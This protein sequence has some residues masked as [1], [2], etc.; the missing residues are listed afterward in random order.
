MCFIKK[1][2]RYA[3]RTVPFVG[4]PEPMNAQRPF[5]VGQGFVK[6]PLSWRISLGHEGKAMIELLEKTIFR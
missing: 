6:R 5:T 1:G 2:G 3:N 4:F